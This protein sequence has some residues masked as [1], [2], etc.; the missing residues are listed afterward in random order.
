MALEMVADLKTRIPVVPQLTYVPQK[1]IIKQENS[2]ISKTTV[3]ETAKAEIYQE[4]DM[5][6]LCR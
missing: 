4:K 6:L 2:P 5:C 1:I 3:S